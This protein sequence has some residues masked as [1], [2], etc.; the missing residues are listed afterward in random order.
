MGSIVPSPSPRQTSQP[1]TEWKYDP[2]YPGGDE[3]SDDA[4]AIHEERQAILTERV[5]TFL[6]SRVRSDGYFRLD[7]DLGF[8]EIARG[9][10]DPET[11]RLF[12]EERRGGDTPYGTWTLFRLREDVFNALYSL[13]DDEL[14]TWVVRHGW[15]HIEIPGAPVR[16][17]KRLEELRTMPYAEYLETREWQERRRVHLEAAGNR[18]QLCNRGE[19]LHVHHRTYKN[20]GNEHF[21]DLIVLCAACHKHFHEGRK[22]AR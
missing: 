1:A 21:G 16:N 8:D 22:V 12:E 20:R 14:I 4:D 7:Y 17:E 9:I 19:R 6:W 10:A 3:W 2:H 5:Y 11:L 13:A 15:P 18:C